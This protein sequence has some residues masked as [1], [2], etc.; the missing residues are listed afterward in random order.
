MPQVTV[1][2]M[3]R[4]PKEL[5]F[6]AITD[7]GNLPE[8]NP[9]I[10]R[11]EFLGDV[12]EGVGTRFR[13]TRRMKNKEM[14]TDLEIT[15]FVGNERARMVADSHGT[16]W[17]TTFTV[18]SNGELTRLEIAMDAN[19]KSLMPRIMNRLFKG[20]FKVGLEKHVGAVK[21]YCEAQHASTA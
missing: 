21:A 10:V 20:L 4:A 9:D 17:D 16:I 19:G 15:E 7:I 6:R 8:T 11:V 2:R 5:V 1:S 13:E 18:T 3:I 12:E 14:P